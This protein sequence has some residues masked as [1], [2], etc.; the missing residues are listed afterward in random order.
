MSRS[1]P[2]PTATIA[3]TVRIATTV[4]RLRRSSG[5]GDGVQRMTAPMALPA[6]R[7]RNGPGMLAAKNRSIG[8]PYTPRLTNA[9]TATA[10]MIQ[11][12]AI[13]DRRGMSNAEASHT[14]PS[15]IVASRSQACGGTPA[16]PLIQSSS[17][18]TAERTGSSAGTP[19]KNPAK[20]RSPNA[21]NGTS[22]ATTSAHSP[23][24]GSGATQT[25]VQTSVNRMSRAVSSIRFSVFR[26][27]VE[28]VSAAYGNSR[29]C[30]SSVRG[31]TARI[32][33][34]SRSD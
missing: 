12:V 22:P 16:L 9:S 17:G 15:A 4:A 34:R 5:I 6:T 21:V 33:A 27:E 1:A 18:L 8:S 32:I 10:G 19:T 25:A 23:S 29:F 24:R 13:R 2:V 3:G 14:S 31:Q 28:R 7:P 11:A 30:H 26:P 20:T